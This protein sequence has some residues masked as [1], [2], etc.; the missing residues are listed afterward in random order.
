MRLETR[1]SACTGTRTNMD[2]PVHIGMGTRGECAGRCR[3]R[4]LMLLLLL[5]LRWMRFG[6]ERTL[7]WRLIY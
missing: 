7:G 1:C 2:G 6:W 4:G 3:W 5:R